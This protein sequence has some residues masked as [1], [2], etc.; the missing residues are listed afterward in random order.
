MDSK[1]EFIAVIQANAGLIYKVTRVY[2]N[3]KEDAQ[4]LYQEIVYQLWKSFA[5]FRQEAKITTWMYR[6]ALNTSVTY[7]NKSKKKGAHVQ[8]DEGLLNQ[9]DAT[10]TLQEEQL[11]ILYAHIKNLNPVEKAIVLLYLEGKTY[12]EIAA[13]TGFSVTNTGT[14]LSRIKQKLIN[15]IH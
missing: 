5:S 1:K 8:V 14:R 13:I 4:D 12:E 11:L 15:Q 6:V 10:D 3:S 7:L 2:T 9:P